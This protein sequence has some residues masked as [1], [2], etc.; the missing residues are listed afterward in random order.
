MGVFLKPRLN[1]VGKFLVK[2]IMTFRDLL[3]HQYCA[4]VNVYCYYRDDLVTSCFGGKKRP[5]AL[6]AKEASRGLARRKLW[7]RKANRDNLPCANGL[8]Y[9]QNDIFKS[10]DDTAYHGDPHKLM[11]TFCCCRVNGKF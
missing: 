2:I 4:C 5:L 8:L 10:L 1:L 3:K 11:S 6:H 9:N 7:R